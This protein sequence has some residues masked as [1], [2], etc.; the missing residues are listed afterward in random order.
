MKA[1]L[2]IDNQLCNDM[3]GKICNLARDLSSLYWHLYNTGTETNNQEYLPMI[4]DDICLLEVL[5]NIAIDS[6]KRRY[7][8]NIE[9]EMKKI[10]ARPYMTSQGAIIKDD[11]IVFTETRYKKSLSEKCIA[12]YEECLNEREKATSQEEINEINKKIEKILKTEDV[13]MIRPDFTKN[14]KSQPKKKKR[15]FENE[16][17]K[18]LYRQKQIVYKQEQNALKERLY[19]RL[20]SP[21]DLLKEVIY[22]PEHLKRSPRTNYIDRFTDILAPIP[23]GIKADYNRIEKIKE[24]CIEAKKRM[25]CKQSEYD[26]GKI[27]FDEMWEEKK[28]IQKDV[29]ANLKDRKVTSLEINK[30]IRDVYDEHPELNKHGRVIRLKNGKPKMIDA[31]DK[32]SNKERSRRMDVAMALF[33]T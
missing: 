17:Q 23:K 29:I 16:E 13:H 28:N 6:A 15:R 4:Y 18:E 25:D 32:K 10:K 7:D 1:W 20:V 5:S 9:A 22:D 30:L 12:D 21:M 31:R 27:S 11:T 2:K 14:L 8:C 33:G 19:K 3:I 26:S 24:V